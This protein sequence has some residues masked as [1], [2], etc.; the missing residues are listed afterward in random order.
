MTRQEIDFQGIASFERALVEQLQNYLEEK[1]THFSDCIA[2]SIPTEPNASEPKLENANVPKKLSSGVEAFTRKVSQATTAHTNTESQWQQ[3]VNAVNEAMCK[4]AELLQQIAVELFQQIDLT[5]IE[6]WRPEL[7]QVVEKI[8]EILLHHMEDLKWALKRLE[9]QLWEY[10]HTTENEN[11]FIGWLCRY[12]P[13][14][15]T[16]IEPALIKNLEKS[17]KF[18]NFRYL[19]FFHRY[20][21][22]NDLNDQIEVKMTKF[23]S[24]HV[25]STLDNEEQEN[26]KRLYRL[27]KLWKLNRQN[28]ALPDDELIRVIRYAINPEKA[29]SFFKNYFQALQNKLFSQSR[30]IKRQEVEADPSD[31][32]ARE[33]EANMK[34]MALQGAIQGQRF[35]LHTLGATISA[36]RS[37]LLRSDPNPYVRTRG[38][39]SEWIVGL[40]PSQTKSLI[41]QE[42]DIEK[43]DSLYLQFFESIKNPE[44]ATVKERQEL[45]HELQLAIYEMG[46]PLASSSL[47]TSKAEHFVQLLD[48]LNELGSRDP[49]VVAQITPLLSKAMRAD[50][51][52]NVLQEIPRFHQLYSVHMQILTPITD[53]NHINRIRHF[54]RLIQQLTQWVKEKNMYIH[55]N[56]IELDINDIKGYLQ[57]FLA[58]LQRLSKDPTYS[59][60]ENL[61]T[62]IDD[63]AQQLLECRYLF[64]HFFNHLRQ[65]EIDEKSLRNQFL[66]VDH[67][68]ETIENKLDDMEEGLIESEES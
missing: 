43:L 28:K 36:Y 63:T 59:L 45:Y 48:K 52:Y 4:Y 68:F 24:Y 50:W 39:F 40:E 19:T 64:C 58:Q 60:K 6:Q 11:K 66:F 15:K 3:T 2:N 38:G 55:L 20:E 26:F 44:E 8:K 56:Q 34:L 65:N 29:A 46:Q 35:E 25:L 61:G 17:Q 9:S 27:L 1:E 57:D 42:Y 22:Y 30:Q 10:K 67:Y 41:D 16:I 12:F 54:K 21:L 5:S 13:L 62:L 53:R 33:N 49:E 51:K 18:L 31:Q 37:F 23:S 7:L 32:S 14:R 47:M